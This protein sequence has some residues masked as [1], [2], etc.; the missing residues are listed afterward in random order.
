MLASWA[1]EFSHTLK[2]ALKICDKF[3]ERL[4]SD[5]ERSDNRYC[6][7]DELLLPF[8]FTRKA[9]V[10]TSMGRRATRRSPSF[11]ATDDR[12]I[13]KCVAF[14]K[15]HGNSTISMMIITVGPRVSESMGAAVSMV[16]PQSNWLTL[17]WRAEATGSKRGN[18]EREIFREGNEGE[19]EEEA[20][21]ENE[22]EREA[23]RESERDG[24]NEGV[25]DEA[26]LDGWPAESEVEGDTPVN[27]AGPLAVSVS[28]AAAAADDNEAAAAAV[29]D[30]ERDSGPVEERPLDERRDAPLALD[31]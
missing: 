18:M 9:E 31:E 1:E 30:D 14:E 2:F 26:V 25:H 19:I 5:S 4:S 21:E 17:A 11:D 24:E 10:A 12:L 28:E 29:V 6:E 15:R 23:E 27:E 7:L 20:D 8:L 3:S 22:G 16:R 13:M